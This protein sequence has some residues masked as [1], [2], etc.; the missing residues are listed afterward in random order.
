MNHLKAFESVKKVFDL[1]VQSGR[2]S[3][4]FDKVKLTSAGNGKCVAEM[5]VEDVHSNIYGT[6]HGGF[7]SSAIDFFSSLAMLTHPKIAYNIDS[8]SKTG[9]S[10]DIHV[11]YL[12]SAKIG[13]EVIINAE[14]IKF[15]R[16]LA[17]L[18][19]I[20]TKKT[21]NIVIAKGSHTKFVV[22]SQT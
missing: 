12:A 6:L 3:R 14:T 9:V 20:M 8:L 18:E 2:F 7:T 11:S 10:V 19:V 22:L 21:D 1:A 15:G 4:N 17:Y 5:I 13:E 16:N